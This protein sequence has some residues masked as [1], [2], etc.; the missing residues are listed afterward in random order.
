M[1]PLF[2]EHH[3]RF[4]GIVEDEFDAGRR[5]FSCPW[6]GHP[7]CF[8]AFTAAIA[9]EWRGE[10]VLSVR[11]QDL[12]EMEEAYGGGPIPALGEALREDLDARFRERLMVPG[13]SSMYRYTVRPDWLRWPAGTDDVKALGP[14]D[15]RLF[16]EFVANRAQLG[17]AWKLREEQ[18]RDRR[19][20]GVWSD[21]ARAGYAEVSDLHVGGGNIAVAI[22]P[23]QRRRGHGRAA[24]AWAAR[25]CL[26]R[27]VVPVYWVQAD[28][29]PSIALAESLG[30]RRQTEEVTVK[31]RD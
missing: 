9:T 19:F 6:R 14:G 1:E 3:R 27:D 31:Y 2:R 29:T 26:E 20:F 28:N 10:V 22:R 5:V 25:W 8:H 18:F 12:A 7:I 4:L 24:V 17:R 30:F 13:V 15:R 16:A 11:P 21:G 23:S